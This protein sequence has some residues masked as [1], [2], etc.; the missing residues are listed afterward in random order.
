MTERE[1]T[2]PVD[3]CREDGSLDPDAVGWARRPLHR[4]NLRRRLGRGWG[5]TKRWEYWGVVSDKYVVGV[6][7]SALDYAAVHGL[8]V[9]ERASGREWRE[10]A[11][12]P[13]GRGV[14]LHD[15]AA[16]GRVAVTSGPI[17]VVAD[18]Q[19]DRTT[20][21]VHSPSIGLDLVLDRPPAQESMSVVVPWSSSRFQYTLKDLALTARGSL[22]LDGVRRT[23]GPHA[24]AVLDH[25]RGV[26]PYK[27][28]W[29]WGAGSGPGGTAVQLGGRWTD[30]TGSTE[31]ALLVDGVV[32]KIGHDLVWTYDRRD[33]SRPWR[34]EGDGVDATLTPFHVRTASTE[35]GVLGSHTHQAFGTWS[36]SATADDGTT[37]DLAGLVGWAEEARNRW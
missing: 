28:A 16:E 6:Q 25:G 23:L 18:Q 13:L 27:A 22:V 4:T 12:V 10:D 29:N 1:I 15:H 31:N 32:H 14:G 24:F 9:L 3:L 26:W 7:V 34:V 17:R 8:Y 30:G 19:R 37:L 20:L 35:L 2:G 36:G 11:T 33:W 21:T 5:R